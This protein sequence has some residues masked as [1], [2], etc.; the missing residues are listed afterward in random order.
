MNGK[1][2]VCALA[3]STQ[4]QKHLL[5]T[6][7]AADRDR[8]PAWPPDSSFHTQ[9]QVQWQHHRLCPT[10]QETVA[11]PEKRSLS[12]APLRQGNEPTVATQIQPSQASPR[13]GPSPSPGP[14]SAQ[15]A[16]VTKRMGLVVK[17]PEAAQRIHGAVLPAVPWNEHRWLAE[18][19]TP[20]KHPAPQA[21]S[22]APTP[23]GG[24]WK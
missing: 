8:G 23:V 12:V 1:Y 15:L 17:L 16:S 21:H 22:C 5:P 13:P 10:S 7:G 18:V 2:H 11:V 6:N 4:H 9:T 20:A 19:T 3:L 14:S 24:G